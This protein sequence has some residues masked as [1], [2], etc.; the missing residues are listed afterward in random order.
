MTIVNLSIT[1][2]EMMLFV[3]CFQ[4]NFYKEVAPDISFAWKKAV[5]SVGI[6]P[7]VKR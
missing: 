6:E 1:F 7:A 2:L 3:V 5:A 4:K